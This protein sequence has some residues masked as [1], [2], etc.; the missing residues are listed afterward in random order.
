MFIKYAL[1]LKDHSGH[2]EPFKDDF[3]DDFDNSQKVF[4]TLE[5]AEKYKSDIIKKY[6]VM[7]ESFKRVRVRSG[8]LFLKR[9]IV[10]DYVYDLEDR[11]LLSSTIKN[12][13]VLKQKINVFRELA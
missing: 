7:K 3:S 4:D 12:I 10:K 13:V 6:S 5:D 2:Y 11:K 1:Y 8:Y 9:D